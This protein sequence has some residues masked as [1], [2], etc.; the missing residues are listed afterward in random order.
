MLDRNQD[1]ALK[2]I[3]DGVRAMVVLLNA[4]ESHLN[5]KKI[6]L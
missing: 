5:P 4:I 6:K 2:E 1:A 3:R